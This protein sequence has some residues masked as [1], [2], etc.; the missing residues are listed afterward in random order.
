MRNLLWFFILMFFNTA[1]V[2]ANPVEIATVQQ[3]KPLVKTA[4]TDS[5]II[6]IPFD[7]K[8]SA[9]FHAFTYDVIDSVVNLLL[10]DSSI[11]LSINGYAHQDEGSDSICKYLSLNRALFVR[12]YI[13]G[14][15]VQPFRIIFVRGMGKKRSGNSNVNKDGHAL[16][17]RA[18]LVL[19]FPPPPAP[20]QIEDKDED[21]IADADD[22]CADEFGYKENNGCPDK[23]A[24]NIPFEFQTSSLSSYTYKAL[25]SVIVVLKENSSFKIA[26]QGHAYKAEGINAVCE[27]LADER[28]SIVKNYFLSRNISMARI[29]SI[30]SFGNRRPFNPGRNPL[31]IGLNSRAEILIKK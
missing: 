21:G 10:K 25:D 15:G 29:V 30:E 19:N 23:D 1:A 27:R 9:L 4:Y 5:S 14:R 3:N 20:P 17:C 11:T 8:Q 12:D 13:L 22:A 7:Y 24:I 26:I 16:N 2:V 18:E 6:L 31:E 28:A